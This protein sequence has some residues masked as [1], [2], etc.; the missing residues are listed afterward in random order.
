[1]NITQPV[2]SHISNVGFGLLS[3]EEIKA[4]SVRKITN[5]QTVNSLLH[6]TVNGLYD[7]SLGSLLNGL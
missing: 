4:L 6:A 5:P 1:M 2:S 3:T 7:P